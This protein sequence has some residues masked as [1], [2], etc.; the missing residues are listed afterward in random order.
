MDG[1]IGVLSTG[2]MIIISC[3]ANTRPRDRRILHH[4]L[5]NVNI[6]E[7][8]N[9]GSNINSSINITE[10]LLHSTVPDTGG[11]LE[12]ELLNSRMPSSEY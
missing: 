9:I 1:S 3:L 2:W 11:G 12:M 8:I 6:T 10:N 4:P 5:N 7:N